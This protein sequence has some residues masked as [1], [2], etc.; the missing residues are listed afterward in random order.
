[1]EGTSF[2]KL[3]QFLAQFPEFSAEKMKAVEAASEFWEFF[4]QG[5]RILV[6]KNSKNNDKL[7][8]QVA[9]KDDIWLHAKDVAGS[10]VIIQN[11][12]GKEM[13]APVLEFAAKL[14]AKNSKRKS[15]ALVPVS[16]TWKKYVRKPKG[17]VAG[18]V[19]VDR[20]TVLLIRQD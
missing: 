7:S 6:G 11:P 15:E 19:L 8:F 4:S 16:W 12:T 13:P 3:N 1:M 18:A 5:Y 14:A 9:K 17:F 20:E 2:E 10:H